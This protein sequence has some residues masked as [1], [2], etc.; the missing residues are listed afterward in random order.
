MSL[1]YIDGTFLPLE[2]ASLPVSDYIILRG[3]GFLNPS[4]PSTEGP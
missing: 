4:A 3:V 1:C 2:K